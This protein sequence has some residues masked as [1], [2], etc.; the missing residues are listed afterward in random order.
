M[1]VTISYGDRHYRVRVDD[2][3]GMDHHWRDRVGNLVMSNIYRALVDF[4]SHD[5]NTNSEIAS[6]KMKLYEL[7]SERPDIVEYMREKNIV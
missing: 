2:D 5:Q 1:N 6:L 4:H 3:M 7:A